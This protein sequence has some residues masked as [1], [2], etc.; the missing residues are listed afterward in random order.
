MQH[1][2]GAE[3]QDGVE[4]RNVLRAVRGDD[5]YFVTWAHSKCPEASGRAA[6][7]AVELSKSL[8]L[9]KEVRRG[10]I[11]VD[12]QI[13]VVNVEESGVSVVK[14]VWCPL[15]VELEPLLVVDC[16]HGEFSTFRLR[17]F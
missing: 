16:R 15:W 3:L 10:L 17:K 11:R 2:D 7:L 9:A 1:G 8:G 5:G 4:G 13:V 12:C 6:N 14:V